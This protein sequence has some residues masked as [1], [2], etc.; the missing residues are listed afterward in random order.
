MRITRINNW[1]ISYRVRCDLAR[2]GT[3]NRFRDPDSGRE[4]RG[5]SELAVRSRDT[6]GHSPTIPNVAFLEVGQ[7]QPV[8]LPRLQRGPSD[9]PG[10]AGREGLRRPRAAPKAVRPPARASGPESPGRARSGAPGW[11]PR[12][13]LRRRGRAARAGSL[14]ITERTEARV[15]NRKSR[16]VVENYYTTSF[17]EHFHYAD[18]ISF[19]V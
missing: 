9:Q 3:D 11:R 8:A 4:K 14:T 10:R 5:E 15:L 7:R 6:S 13:G 1:W 12:P 17:I 16:L 2:V 18:G 19:F